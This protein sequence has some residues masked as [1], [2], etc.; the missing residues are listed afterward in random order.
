MAMSPQ[1]FERIILVNRKIKEEHVDPRLKFYIE[2]VDS[3]RIYAQRSSVAVLA[4]SL[5]IPIVANLPFRGKDIL[6]STMAASIAFISGFSQ[7]HRWQETWKEYSAAIVK[8]EAAI[9][10]WE[11][12]IAQLDPAGESDVISRTLAAATDALVQSVSAIVS[13]EMEQ[14]FQSQNRQAGS[15]GPT[16]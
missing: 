14:F 3:K 7:I 15:G 11:L 10:T 2:R 8:V 5:A 1:E 6:V 13:T 12:K 16:S 4:L 9:A